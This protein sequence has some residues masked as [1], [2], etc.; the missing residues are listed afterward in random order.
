[1]EGKIDKNGNLIMKRGSVC[2]EV[3]CENNKSYTCNDACAC[4]CEP[5]DLGDERTLVDLC[6]VAHIFDIFTDER[7]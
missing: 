3:R 4:F 7:E 5:E 1:M 2:K 6:K